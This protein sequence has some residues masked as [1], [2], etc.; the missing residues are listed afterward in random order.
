[1]KPVIFI[2]PVFVLFFSSAHGQDLKKA[3]ESEVD[4]G[5]VQLAEKFADTFLTKSR[6]G[7]WYQF[8]DEAIDEIKA[9]L[10]E[11]KQKASYSQIKSTFG[12]YVSLEYAETWLSPSNPGL[13]LI[14]F[15][16][17]FA[18]S[19]NK[20]EIRVVLNKSGKISG[21]WIKPWSETL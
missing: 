12:D 14:R 9:A 5:S 20:A 17:Q 4:K 6:N 16:G 8:T 11:E 3:A 2:I 19:A 1:M 21:F 7:S 10:T 13:R 15:K 18:S